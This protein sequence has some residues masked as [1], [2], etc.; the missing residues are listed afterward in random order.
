MGI[1]DPD[2]IDARPGSEAS[3]GT[4]NRLQTSHIDVQELLRQYAKGC[5]CERYGHRHKI[6]GPGILTSIGLRWAG[7]LDVV[8]RSQE[9][10]SELIGTIPSPVN[11][12]PEV[13]AIQPSTGPE[14]E[15]PE[16]ISH[17]HETTQT[18]PLARP[19]ALS[20]HHTAEASVPSTTARSKPQD[21]SEGYPWGLWTHSPT[22][23]IDNP[24]LGTTT[25]MPDL[26]ISLAFRNAQKQEADAAISSHPEAVS[27]PC[28]DELQRPG[29]DAGTRT[30]Q[31]S[32]RRRTQVQTRSPLMS[33]PFPFIPFRKA[34][35]GQFLNTLLQPLA[36]KERST[37][38]LYAFRRANDWG[39][40]KI[41]YTT[42]NIQERLQRWRS[43][44]GYTADERHAF[45]T[46]PYVKRAEGPIHV[47]L[48][49]NRYLDTR[50]TQNSERCGR[51]HDEWFQ[52]RLADAGQVINTI[53]EWMCVHHPYD[54]DGYILEK[55][56]LH[57]MESRPWHTP[58]LLR[59]FLQIDN[60]VEHLASDAEDF[61]F[62]TMPATND[63]TSYRG[64]SAIGEAE[65]N[66]T[67][68]EGVDSAVN[69][70]VGN[71]T[72]TTD[73]GESVVIQHVGEDDRTAT[74][75]ENMSTEEAEQELASALKTIKSML[76]IGAGAISQHEHRAS[77]FQG[78]LPQHSDGPRT[79]STTAARATS[80]DAVHGEPSGVT[81]TRDT[82]PA[83][84][85]V[86]PVTTSEIHGS[87]VT[88]APRYYTRSTNLQ[89]VMSN[90]SQASKS[91]C[92]EVAGGARTHLK[93]LK[94]KV[95]PQHARTP[96]HSSRPVESS[97]L[98]V[99]A[100]KRQNTLQKLKKRLTN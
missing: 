55:W 49:Q 68:R 5:C 58:T 83:S 54:G 4:S 74:T 82:V 76:E 45:H 67:I 2:P 3:N 38:S 57:F 18:T 79:R 26:A 47:M 31:T 99:R 8:L 88:P 32:P 50:C 27:A 80:Q 37:G 86:D 77:G 19:A 33:S 97:P 63:R 53:A 70:D 81:G 100:P 11:Q 23:S 48:N 52:I 62:N 75:K 71:T 73:S 28:G 17:V 39:F 30:V 20:G 43:T 35:P 66:V 7:E 84:V 6:D 98:L 60:A 89:T 34:S 51:F 14:V 12:R 10:R 22:L 69:E 29:R 40:L 65:N 85:P 36:Q 41:G 92:S 21:G 56:R 87:S 61:D 90:V 46:V 95:N 24:A 59:A 93:S 15:Q 9:L 91:I 96:Q 42:G 94:T 25:S 44:C 13:V 72:A 1:V 16:P 78:P 64:T